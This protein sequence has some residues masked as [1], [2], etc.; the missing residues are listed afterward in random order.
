MIEKLI[1]FL[2][3]AVTCKRENQDEWMEGFV[4]DINNIL[5]VIGDSDRFEYSHIH[6]IIRKKRG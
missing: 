4:K 3:Y 2:S 6:G 1:D 5:K